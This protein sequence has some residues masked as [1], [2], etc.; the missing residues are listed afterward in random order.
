[1]C[2]PLLAQYW[3]LLQQPTLSDAR[4]CSF[5]GKSPAEADKLGLVGFWQ[6]AQSPRLLAFVC[7][8]AEDASDLAPQPGSDE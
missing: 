4:A 2:F 6:L 1:M 7:A 8:R 5:N 3:S